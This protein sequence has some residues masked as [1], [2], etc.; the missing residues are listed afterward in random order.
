MA[1]SIQPCDGAPVLGG[2]QPV[3]GLVRTG[4]IGWGRRAPQRCPGENPREGR[5]WKAG[6]NNLPK[7]L[8]HRHAPPRHCRFRVRDLSAPEDHGVLRVVRFV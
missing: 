8:I 4:V 5:A 1:R 6:G 7:Q 3:P 2:D